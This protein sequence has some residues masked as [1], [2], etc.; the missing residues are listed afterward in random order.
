MKPLWINKGGTERG[1]FIIEMLL[2]RLYDLDHFLNLNSKENTGKKLALNVLYVYTTD[3]HTGWLRIDSGQVPYLRSGASWHVQLH[4]LLDRVRLVIVL[5]SR[6]LG[7]DR[8]LLLSRCSD[9]MA[10][11]PVNAPSENWK[12]GHT[13]GF[14]L[15]FFSSFSL[16]ASYHA[17]C[18]PYHH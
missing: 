9:L 18:C 15:F 8:S 5:N 14:A 10:V 6:L 11:M 1:H 4:G 3:I 2:N 17:T 13:W 16:A 7:R 12:T